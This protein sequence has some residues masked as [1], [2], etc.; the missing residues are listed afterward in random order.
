[1]DRELLEKFTYFLDCGRI[2]IKESTGIV[3]FTV[4]NFK[5]ITEK[6]I[7]FFQ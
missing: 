3:T 4:T 1:M 2:S 5:D 6:I 7:P